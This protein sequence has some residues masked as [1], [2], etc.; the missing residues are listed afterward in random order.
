MGKN[1]LSIVALVLG[2]TGLGLAILPSYVIQVRDE[3]KTLQE[4]FESV[5]GEI[6]SELEGKPK[7]DPVKVFQLVS[8]GAAFAGL[9]L[10]V[11]GLA[12]REDLRIAVP[13]VIVS[14]V[15]LVLYIA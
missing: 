3:Q 6:M 8:V 4:K 12:R 5:A 11:A 10:G 9:A 15:T 1:G 2:F 14:C 13:A 7:A